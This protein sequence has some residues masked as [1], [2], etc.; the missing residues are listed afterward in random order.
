VWCVC[1]VYVCLSVY[2]DSV[3][4]PIDDGES[5]GMSS[6]RIGSASLTAKVPTPRQ[7]EGAD[8]SN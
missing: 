7:A 5:T 8:A 3:P 6:I 2:V 1:V 4:Y